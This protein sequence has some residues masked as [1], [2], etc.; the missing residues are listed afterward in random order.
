MLSTW[1]YLEDETEEHM[2]KRICE[3][4]D[5][6]ELVFSVLIEA[7]LKQLSNVG[8]GKLYQWMA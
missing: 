6:N 3:F 1:R 5:T 7:Y 8:S 2:N 4:G